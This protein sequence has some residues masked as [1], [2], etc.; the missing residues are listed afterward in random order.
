M[1]M[2]DR[3]GD[4]QLV[5]AACPNGHP[6][7]LWGSPLMVEPGHVPNLGGTPIVCGECGARVG[8]QQR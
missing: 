5:Q 6:I 1:T 2:A 4:G 3:L 7:R 8:V